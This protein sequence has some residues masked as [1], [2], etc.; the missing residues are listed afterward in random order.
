MAG[1]N[2]VWA[3]ADHREGSRGST[4]TGSSTARFPPKRGTVTKKA[5]AAIVH[6]VGLC[7][8]SCAA[9]LVGEKP[10]NSNAT[11]PEPPPPSSSS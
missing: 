4:G 7:C 2:K 8:D 11:P 10:H 3:L 1:S 9:C 5:A 6:G